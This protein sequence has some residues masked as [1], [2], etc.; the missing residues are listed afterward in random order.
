PQFHRAA[1]HLA[2]DEI[3]NP[4]KRD[5]DCKARDGKVGKLV[6][7]IIS[8][9]DVKTTGERATD[10]SAM[11]RKS[12]V[13]DANHFDPGALISRPIRQYVDRSSAEDA[14]QYDDEH[15]IINEVI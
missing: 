3:C 15:Q 14:S 2:V 7:G 10:H 1:E 13:V 4:N 5:P 9:S 11:K 6:K 8:A 12:A